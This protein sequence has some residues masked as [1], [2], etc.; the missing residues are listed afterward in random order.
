MQQHVRMPSGCGA[1][2]ENAKVSEERVLLVNGRVGPD[3]TGPR[4]GC[5]MG[6]SLAKVGVC[7]RMA[8]RIKSVRRWVSTDQPSGCSAMSQ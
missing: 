5:V 1:V 3:A 2:G 8:Q 6:S 7:P 4:R